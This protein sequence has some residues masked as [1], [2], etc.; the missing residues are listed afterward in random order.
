MA[1]TQ[2][3]FADTAW[4]AAGTGLTTMVAQAIG[5]RVQMH[6]GSVAPSASDVGFDLPQGLAV[7]VP[8]LT[9]LGGSVWVRSG[10]GSGAFRYAAA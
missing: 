1:T 3:L 5:D 9:A 6:I 8:G 7:E 4:Q 10:D 2:I